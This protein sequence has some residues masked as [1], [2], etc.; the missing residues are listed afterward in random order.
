MLRDPE[1]KS[2][3]CLSR[4]TRTFRVAIVIG[5]MLCRSALILAVETESTSPN[6]FM[7]GGG[8]RYSGSRVAQIG[9]RLPLYFVENGGHI[10]PRVAY[11]V[12][13]SDKVIYFA[14]DGLTLVLGRP[15]QANSRQATAKIMRDGSRLTTAAPRR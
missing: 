13:A 8:H 5:L 4:L 12:Q 3:S 9:D 2:A 1:T 15:S 7:N 10:D 14:P 11:Y 6:L